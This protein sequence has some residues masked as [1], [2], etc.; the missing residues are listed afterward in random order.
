MSLNMVAGLVWGAGVVGWYVIR[1]PHALRARRMAVERAPGRGLELVLLITSFTGL[2]TVPFAWVMLGWPR[3]ANYAITPWQIAAGAL[4]FAGSLRLFA[5]THR[6][7]GK[8]WSVTLEVRTQHRLVTEGVYAR[9]R[10]P[11]YAAFWLWALAQAIILPNAVAGLAGLVGFGTLYF[12]RV[13]REERMMREKFGKDY[14]AYAARTGRVI[15][16]IRA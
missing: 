9:V 2:F 10:H 12:V 4:V 15:P 7:L 8:N 16:R 13:G 6:D 14:D 5:K 1:F 11:M 3:A